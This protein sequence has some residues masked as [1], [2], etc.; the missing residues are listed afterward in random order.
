MPS[1][2]N[3]TPKLPLSQTGID[4][5]STGRFVDRS[6]ATDVSEVNGKSVVQFIE[7]I[8]F[9]MI[10]ADYAREGILF[11]SR[12]KSQFPRRPRIALNFVQRIVVEGAKRAASIDVYA[13]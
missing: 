3:L 13:E 7:V 5:A 10:E 6:I 4:E 12:G 11:Q 8:G 2:E 9:V 1:H